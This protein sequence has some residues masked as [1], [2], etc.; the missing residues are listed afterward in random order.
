MKEGD[1]NTKF[2]YCMANARW[3][4]NF[5]SSLTISGI[6]LE[7]VEELKEIIFSYFKAAFEDP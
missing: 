4:G 3:N 6:R 2:V 7:K 5:I 1:K